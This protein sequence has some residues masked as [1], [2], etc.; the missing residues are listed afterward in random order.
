MITVVPALF[1][2]VKQLQALEGLLFTGE[3][4]DDNT[5]MVVENSI[6]FSALDGERVIGCGG[7]I[8]QW[9]GVGTLWL[10]ASSEFKHHPRT[11]L[12]IAFDMVE[13]IRVRGN[14]HR[15]QAYVAAE[16]SRHIRFMEA[17]GFT[18][19]GKLVKHTV[20]KRDHLLYAKTF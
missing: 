1:S 13:K 3:N 12:R 9:H 19:E 14:F 2:H 8:R 4:S 10:M 11:I 7:V 5:R 15:L 18:F 17:L 20:D 6:A 16:D